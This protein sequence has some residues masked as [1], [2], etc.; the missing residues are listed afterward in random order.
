MTI[1]ADLQYTSDH[2][3]IKDLGDGT[4]RIG[5]TDYAQDQLGD[6]VYVDLPETDG[7]VESGSVIAEVESTKSVGE[8]YAPMR[9]T[10]VA[11]NEAVA[12]N[13]ELVNQEPYGEGWLVELYASDPP[14]D[15]LSAE[16]YEKLI[17]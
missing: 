2:E 14:E 3:W 6:I 10:V 9:G 16:E 11:V 1:P 8:V 12:D 13:P 7:S 5:I 17:D 15:V 4:F